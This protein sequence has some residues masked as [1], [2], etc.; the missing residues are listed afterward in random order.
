MGK[1]L[2]K[3]LYPLDTVVT[4]D[5]YLIGTDIDQD[6]KTV[7]FNVG[8]ILRLM[9]SEVNMAAAE[10]RYSDGGDPEIVHGTQGFFFSNSATDSPNDTTKLYVSKLNAGGVDMS[11]MFTFLGANQFSFGLKFI[12]TADPNQTFNFKITGVTVQADHYEFDVAPIGT[13]Y[14]VNMQDLTTYNVYMDVLGAQDNKFVVKQAPV[15]GTIDETKAAA[16][17]NALPEFTVNDEQIPLY[18]ITN[19][20]GS[21]ITYVPVGKGKGTYGTNGSQLTAGDLQY[22]SS[23]AAGSNANVV[24]QEAS[25]AEFTMANVVSALN[26]LPLY[27]VNSG[28]T[29]VYRVT[30]QDGVMHVFLGDNLAVGDYGTGEIQL[31]EANLIE[32]AALKEFVSNVVK[33]VAV[34]TAPTNTNVAAAVDALA[35]FTVEKDQTLFIRA[36]Q[37]G[38]TRQSMYILSGRSD[39]NYGIGGTA[40]DPGKLEF[41]SVSDGTRSWKI[42]VNGIEV[43]I[44]D[45]GESV[46]FVESGYINVE[47]T[48][49]REI[50]ISTTQELQD[51]LDKIT[52]IVPLTQAQYDSLVAGGNIDPTVMYAI[53][54][55]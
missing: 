51:Q 33:D 13:G 42:N 20:S 41:L 48:A 24:L 39:G 22:L 7:N 9:N 44:V 28:S 15:I 29:V 54:C 6:L 23:S 11:Q 26:G 8:S 38:T 3:T 18:H 19:D 35:A 40:L 14:A 2:D 55:A 50:T 1:I 52:Q 30:D 17:I 53:T 45:I 12:S 4:K 43:D 16:A 5:D 34:A 32:V 31:V 47:R 37:D 46:D 21:E 36:T 10:F 27:S 49:E 25:I